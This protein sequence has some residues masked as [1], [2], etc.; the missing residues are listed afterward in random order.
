MDR[1]AY[2]NDIISKLETDITGLKVQ[3]W[4]RNPEEYKTLSKT[5]AILVRYMG[6]SL[7]EPEL[8]REKCLSQKRT[9]TWAITV[10]WRNSAG[11]HCNSDETES[12]Y[13]YLE[14]VETSLTGYTVN[15]VAHSSVLTPV[16][17]E[18]VDELGG[19][20]IFEI[21]FTHTIEEYAGFQA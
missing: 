9:I 17:D 19:I 1:L 12:A 14:E 20:W 8:N 18:F 6:S 4:P 21:V 16:S 5:G 13:T 2:E 11:K 10:M 15:S 7:D 3:G